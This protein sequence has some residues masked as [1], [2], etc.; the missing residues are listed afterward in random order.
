MPD[1]KW[2]TDRAPDT[3][4]AA[5]EPHTAPARDEQPEARPDDR[6]TMLHVDMLSQTTLDPDYPGRPSF[7]PL[8]STAVR[9][10]LFG[11]MAFVASPAPGYPDAIEV[12]NDWTDDQLVR[13]VIPQLVGVHGAPRGAGIWFH[14]RGA[15]ALQALWQAWEDRGLLHLILS[16]DGAYRIRFARGQAH[17]KV[18]SRHA[19]GT[20]FDINAVFNRN[21]AAPAALKQPGCVYPLVPVA[22]E[23]GFFWGGH[24]ARPSGG[25]FELARVQG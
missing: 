20:A 1:R 12:T 17:R 9:Q 7:P 25:H 4:T 8:V 13:V 2:L 10:A 23:F 6:V 18:L 11:P 14:Q 22:H 16:F 3:A 21:G 24:F 19:F 15:T 5:A